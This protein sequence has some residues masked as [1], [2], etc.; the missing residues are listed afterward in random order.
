MM[1]P[2]PSEEPPLLLVLLPELFPELVPLLVPELVP[3]LFPPLL[4]TPLDVVDP[5]PPELP[6]G[7]SP[8]PES[9]PPKELSI[10]GLELQPYS[11]TPVAIVAMPIHRIIF[12]APSKEFRCPAAR[13]SKPFTRSAHDRVRTFG[14]A[15]CTARAPARTASPAQMSPRLFAIAM[16]RNVAGDVRLQAKFDARPLRAM[17]SILRDLR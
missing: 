1:R 2:P 3:L 11:D 6:V 9:S 8:P 15:E 14:H 4:D 13:G 10:C 7:L 17:R 12:M 5:L 16:D